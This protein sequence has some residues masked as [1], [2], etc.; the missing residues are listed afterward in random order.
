M[1]AMSSLSRRE[2]LGVSMGAA[3]VPLGLSSAAEPLATGLIA[4][5]IRGM[6]LGTALGDALGGPIEFQPRDAVQRLPQPPKLWRD[7]DVLD[8]QARVETQRRLQLRSYR[9]LRAEP[10]SYGQWN[11][12]SL[13]GTVTDDTRH[14][15]ILMHALRE[16]ERTGRWPMGV[17]EYAQAYLDWPGTVAVTGQPGYPAMAVDWLEEYQF[18]ARWVVGE[19]DLGKA[20]PPERL[21]NGLPTCAGQMALL[22]IAAVFAGEPELAYRACYQLAF[23]DNGW[24]KDMIAALVAGLAAALV[25]PLDPK[26]PGVA[27]ESILRVMRRT[28]PYGYGRIRWTERSVDRWLNLASKFSRESEGRPARLFARLEKTFEHTTKWEA[29]VPFVVVF[30]CLEL[31]AYDPLASLQ[32]SMEWGHDTDSYAQ[33]LGAFVGALHG[34]ELFPAEW[35]E[36]V[37]T[38]LRAD[39]RVE[40]EAECAF[41]ERLRERAGRQ[42]LFRDP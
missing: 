16:A 24:G 12:N 35:R 15:L 4:T 31:A 26:T 3:V 33:L 38:R 37:S 5:R 11:R 42:P 27:W 30:S 29:Q 39:H 17:K 36:A 7:E 20:R 21:W 22:P 40:L 34:P 14:K 13:P 23:I 19:R 41:L 28:D 25:T 6:M 8:G 18:A 1:G 32:L 10:E 2:F 9:E